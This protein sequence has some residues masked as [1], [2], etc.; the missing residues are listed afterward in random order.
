MTVDLT[1]GFHGR[2]SLAE[3]KGYAGQDR[4]AVCQEGSPERSHWSL[5]RGK[6]LGK[7]VLSA[8]SFLLFSHPAYWSMCNVLLDGVLNVLSPILLSKLSHRMAL[9][10]C[11]SHWSSRSFTAA[12]FKKLDGIRN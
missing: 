11:V 7:P 12:D 8:F 9:F 5:P 3:L 6:A 2:E 10:L 1:Q 4:S